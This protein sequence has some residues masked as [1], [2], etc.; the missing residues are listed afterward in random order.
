MR[1]PLSSARRFFPAG[2]L[3]ALLGL[4]GPLVAAAGSVPAVVPGAEHIVVYRQAG[5]YSAFPVFYQLPDAAP[6]LYVHFGA[7]VTSSHLEPRR[8]TMR[9][10]STDGGRTWQRTTR[11]VPNPAWATG[12]T[13]PGRYVN[14]GA[15]AWRYVEAARRGEFEARGIEVRNSPDGRVTYAYGCYVRTSEDG[16]ATWQHTEIPVPPKALIMGFL[17]PA[18]DLR[19]DARTLLCAVYGRP[20]ANVRFYEAWLLRSEDDGAT[21]DFLTLAADPEKKR[22]FGETALVE[23][24]NGDV[25]AMMRTEP[26][27]GTKMWTTRSSDRGRTW[28]R[29]EETPL[30]GHPPHLLRLRDGTLLCTYGFRDPPIGIR[31]ALSRDHGRTW[32]EQDIVSLRA[33]GGGR[34]GDNGYPLTTEL[35]DGT[36]VTA[37][38]LTREG[39]T[40]VEVTRWRNP[41]K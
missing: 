25:I 32:R 36:L 6:T 27:L 5:Q 1:A 35:P 34:P 31:A 24:A 12:S 19:L 33:D 29:A 17:D 20:T 41:W 40:G 21:W 28:S 22:S 13:R 18:T 37:Y 9:F 38:Y 2:P 15:H 26:A 7:G 10:T 39:I 3:R 14:P 30:H 16:G 11:E 8:E 23:A 4:A